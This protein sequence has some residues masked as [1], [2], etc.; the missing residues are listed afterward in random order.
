[1]ANSETALINETVTDEMIISPCEG[2]QP[3]AL[4]ADNLCEE[5]AHPFLF[6]TGKFGY[7]VEREVFLSPI[8]YFNQ[9]LLNYTQKFAEDS[10]YIFFAQNI[11]QHL[12][13]MSRINI[14]MKKV[15]G[16]ITAG[17]LLNNYEN[18]VK[19]MLQ[20]EE[21]YKFLS[22]VKGSPAYWKLFFYDVLAMVR[23]LGLPTYFLTLS[24][25]DLHW[26]ELVY[27]ILKL[28]GIEIAEDE[29][30]NMSYADRCKILNQN[31]V[32][33]SRQFQYRVELFFKTIIINGPLGKT[34]YYA[35]RVEFQLRGSPHI[36]S[37]VWILNAP[38]LCKENINEYKT[39]IDATVKADMPDKDENPEL[40]N[41]VKTYQVHSQS[42]S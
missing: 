29:I 40:F 17:M 18:T 13:I 22:E 2:N 12:R 25:A 41:L 6:P 20:N 3:L 10:D 1:M 42:K 30:Q 34:L 14:A 24:C 15:H 11:T 21:A 28:Q 16:N 38:V 31:P 27:I 7:K 4:F 19:T 35:I 33:L 37:F 36:H 5:L 9:R 39:F 32:L 26:N 8:R 23:Q